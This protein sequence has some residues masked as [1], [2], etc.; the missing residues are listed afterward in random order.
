MSDR[1]DGLLPPCSDHERRRL[2]ALRRLDVIHTPAEPSLDDAVALVALLVGAHAVS[3]TLVDTDVAWTKA[4]TCGQYEVP[5]QA[6]VADLAIA[7]VGGRAQRVVVEGDPLAGHP[8]LAGLAFPVTCAAVAVLAPEGEPVGAL[9][10]VW[11]DERD[12]APELLDLLDRFGSQTGHLLELR[13]EASEYHRFIDLSPEPVTVLDVDGRI[14]LANPALAML[15]G[16]EVDELM[17]RPFLDLVDRQDRTRATSDLARVLF[18]RSRSAQLDLQL[19]RADGE[20]VTCSVSAAHL[21]GAR[22]HMQL[23]IHDLSERLRGEEERSR[24]SEQLARAQR[25]DAVG[26][27]A[28][29]LAHDLNNLLVVMVSNLGLAEESLAEAQAEV[30]VEPIASL[31]QDLDE[32]KLAVDRAGQLTSKLLEFAQ[33][34][35][36]QSGITHVIDAVEAVAGLIARSLGAGVKLLVEVEDDLPPVA[37]DPVKLE[38]ALVNLVINASDAMPDGG[39]VRIVARGLRAAPA[40]ADRRGGSRPTPAAVVVEVIDDGVGMDANVQA[41]AFE[42]LYTTKG[43]DGT[44][45]GLVTVAAFADEIDGTVRLESTPGEGTCVALILPAIDQPA[46]SVPVGIDVPVGGARVLLVDP[47]ERTRRVIAQMLQ[48]A[49]Y[50]VRAVGSA[51]EALGQ[52]GE[53]APDLLVTELALPGMSGVRLVAELQ[54]RRPEIRAVALATVDAPR[55]LDGTPVLVKPFSHTRLLRTV[56][57]VMQDR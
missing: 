7:A 8:T 54:R 38:R 17:G 31:R 56:E 39:S 12:L 6:S 42:P 16:S 14:V 29:G 26:R 33:R 15:L 35:D 10:I 28:G 44:G 50:R 48:G 19:R 55:T 11:N 25:L 43:E 9:E 30:G 27:V 20:V 47:G 1:I 52:L 41:R 13:A 51:E 46:F 32:M 5:R 34:P 57:R 36:G 22:R 21:R 24:L 23:V 40:V 3:L 18:A 49:G 53:L 45:L 2:E 37:A 4:G